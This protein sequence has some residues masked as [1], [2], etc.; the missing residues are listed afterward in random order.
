MRREERL[1]QFIKLV[2]PFLKPNFGNS[3][4]LD[5]LYGILTSN[6]QD[7][8][9]KNYLKNTSKSKSNPFVCLNANHF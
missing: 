8:D 1:K 2:L 7:K 3:P 4:H 6:G 9:D 5:S